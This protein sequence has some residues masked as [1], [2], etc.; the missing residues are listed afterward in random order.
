M[1]EV[2]RFWVRVKVRLDSVGVGWSTKFGTVKFGSAID[3]DKSSGPFI[4][5]NGE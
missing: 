3:I 2:F 4:W 1:S 5:V